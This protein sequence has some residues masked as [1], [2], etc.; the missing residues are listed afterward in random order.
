MM[1]DLILGV[2]VF[3]LLGLSAFFSGSET[4]LFAL[5]S[6]QRQRLRK[7]QDRPARC[8]ASLLDR[9]PE[10]LATILVGNTLVNILI[11]VLATR[12]LINHLGPQRGVAAST[13][14]VTLT[15]LI[16]GEIFPK[17]LAVLAPQNYSLRISR[18][19]VFVRRVLGP[20]ARLLERLSLRLR[21]ALAGIVA[22]DLQDRSEEELVALV[23][24]A[25][26]EGDLGKKELELVRGVFELADTPVEETMTPRVDCFLLD[27][28]TPI[29]EALPELRAEEF[30]RVPLYNERPDRV[31]GVLWVADLI[32]HEDSQDP[33]SSLARPPRFCPESQMAGPL[34]K[35]MLA[36]GEG[37]AVVMDEYGSLAG[38]ASLEDLYEVLVGEI[39]TRRDL[40]SQRYYMPDE[41]TL[42]ASARL[43]LEQLEELLGVKLEEHWA[44]TLG[45]YLMEA[46]GEVPKTGRQVRLEGLIWTVLDAEGPAL[47]TLRLEREP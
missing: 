2:S 16:V 25:V 41:N 34:L 26:E 45:G 19:L 46:L 28:D 31:V 14:I 24:V 3:L 27:G 37:L 6:G 11:A 5:D 39:F 23:S 42:V 18:P 13:V 35:E 21:T 10:A 1:L 36:E 29:R 17:S 4:A 30:T 12:L 15:V 9:L 33:V 20:L 7:R 43:E 8:V 38:L 32:G 44:E 40:E 22:P 47:K